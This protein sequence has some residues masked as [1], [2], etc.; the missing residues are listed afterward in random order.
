MHTCASGH[1]N[2]NIYIYIYI[3]RTRGK[4]IIGMAL[5][6]ININTLGTLVIIAFTCTC[7]CRYKIRQ[8]RKTSFTKLPNDTPKSQYCVVKILIFDILI[9]IARHYIKYIIIVSKPSI[10]YDTEILCYTFLK[11]MIYL[12]G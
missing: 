3:V 4:A 6:A 11:V 8:I 1:N 12:P 5:L 9:C 10:I 7:T 2:I